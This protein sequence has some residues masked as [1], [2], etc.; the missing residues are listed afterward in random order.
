MPRTITHAIAGL[1]VGA[2]MYASGAAGAWSEGKPIA[3]DEGP[4]MRYTL[5]LGGHARLYAILPAEPAD[6]MSAPR[7]V[8]LVPRSEI[9][10]GSR[11]WLHYTQHTCRWDVRAAAWAN[12]VI[13]D[14]MAVSLPSTSWA[15]DATDDASEPGAPTA[16]DTQL[17]ETASAPELIAL[18]DANRE[19]RTTILPAPQMLDATT[20]F[21][22]PPA[23][24]G[25]NGV[26]GNV[27]L[28]AQ[29]DQGHRVADLS[30]AAESLYGSIARR[31]LVGM[32]ASAAMV[33]ADGMTL[34]EVTFEQTPH[35]VLVGVAVSGVAPGPHGIH[36][37][38][39][40][41]CTPD[42][43][44]ASGHINPHGAAHG[45]R[46][47]DGPDNGDLPLLHVAADGTAVTEFYTTLVSLSDDAESQTPGF[48]DADG[49]SVI[50]HADPDDHL[51]QPI[52]G[53]GARIGC[54]VIEPA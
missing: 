16:L 37:H 6:G 25:D 43:T 49:S 4:L 27:V 47:P 44:A 8:H 3:S 12:L 19:M 46:H 31:A 50:I 21:C 23:A 17:L 40:G 1:T 32:R 39:V 30:D 52:G 48:F 24:S 26:A 15:D 11:H 9:R 20:G 53:A 38:R 13:G 42:F 51:T 34:G 29:M 28:V 54:G 33:G 41:S 45:L 35:G 7:A 2:C 36:L 22:M 10:A 18:F 5:D 14:R